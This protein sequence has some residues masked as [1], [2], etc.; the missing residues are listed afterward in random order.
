MVGSRADCGGGHMVGGKG[1]IAHV[2]VGHITIASGQVSFG[3]H[4]IFGSTVEHD[5][6]TH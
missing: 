4:N 2:T 6:S 5:I 1:S 3:S